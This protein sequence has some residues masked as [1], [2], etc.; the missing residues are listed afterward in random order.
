MLNKVILMGRFVRDP[1]LRYTTTQTPVSSFTLA[2]DD[3]FKS[4]EERKAQFI[5]C[6]AWK[7]TAEFISKYFRKGS[8]AAVEG[9]LQMR[10]WTDKEGN[11]R[12]TAEV[13][14]ANAYFGESRRDPVNNASQD[15][16]ELPDDEEE[17]PF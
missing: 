1:E 16:E 4:G 11:K 6:V 10:D 14:V 17:L 15:F 2:V 13:V 3:D 9:R 12:R 7:G 8:M 5:E